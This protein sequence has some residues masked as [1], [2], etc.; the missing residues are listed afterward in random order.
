[1]KKGISLEFTM[2]LIVAT[3]MLTIGGVAVAK[4]LSGFD[5]TAYDS[6]QDFSK[7]ATAMAAADSGT[8]DGTVVTVYKK[9]V[10]V[11]F[12]KEPYV[13]YFFN[14]D[15]LRGKIG[16][17]YDDSET[18]FLFF[19]PVDCGDADSCICACS[20]I[21]LAGEGEPKRR[22]MNCAGDVKCT[23]GNAIFA[24]AYSDC[25]SVEAVSKSTYSAARNCV[26][27]TSNGGF[28]V[29]RLFGDMTEKQRPERS[30][31]RGLTMENYRGIIGVCTVVPCM[32]ADKKKRMDIGVFIRRAAYACIAGESC[33]L[34]DEIAKTVA[35]SEREGWK[36]R[37]EQKSLEVP[38]SPEV[39]SSLSS[40][41]FHLEN[42]KFEEVS[43]LIEN[44]QGIKGPFREWDD[45][46]TTRGKLHPFPF[47]EMN[48]TPWQNLKSYI[49]EQ[50]SVT[51]NP[52]WDTLREADNLE[53]KQEGS[54][55]VM[56]DKDTTLDMFSYVLVD[57]QNNLD[58]PVTSP[59]YPLVFVVKEK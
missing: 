40:L 51:G 28:V 53:W 17:I 20:D 34:K 25:S 10:L 4:M 42:D 21:E 22:Q 5:S 47:D 30:R 43:Y 2:A 49:V 37:L 13:R 39:P 31:Q 3:V 7:K 26:V 57:V 1:M 24:N 50:D 56:A 36:L 45:K 29:G 14:Q 59:P 27:S 8:A 54:D 41:R 15:Y 33:T 46:S 52:K 55:V 6:Y 12:N 48:S 44:P 18:E 23:K 32:T 35:P 11:G 9:G 58:V 16:H 19:K 38:K